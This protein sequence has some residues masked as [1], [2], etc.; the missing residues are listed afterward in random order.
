[1]TT[2][3]TQTILE[4][5]DN[6]TGSI[7]IIAHNRPD[8]DSIGSVLGLALALD[9]AGKKVAIRSEDPVPEKYRFLPCVDL[10]RELDA[11][12]NPPVEL[13]MILD[14][15]DFDRI[16]A[17]K[18]LIPPGV[19]VIN[20]DH[21]A[22]NA[23]FGDISWIDPNTAATGEMIVRLLNEGGIRIPQDCAAG[24]LTA[25][26]TDTGSFQYAQTTAETLRIAANLI[27]AGAPIS[28]L[29]EAL[30]MQFSRQR[31][32][33]LARLLDRLNFACGG[34][35]CYAWLD[36]EI[37]R[38]TGATREETE[39]LIDHIRAI[40]GVVVA[41]ILERLPDGQQIRMSLRSKNPDVNVGAIAAIYGGG[42]HIAAAGAHIAEPHAEFESELVEH[43][44]KTIDQAAIRPRA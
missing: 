38:K 15:A 16:G 42:G 12:I 3:P 4:A 9:A 20:I 27:E 33:L 24:L 36:S 7:L 19:T 1:M 28:D 37:F 34:H 5:I 43:V 40:E 23:G 35:F 14:C 22:T 31:V 41:A 13:V 21:H 26:I 32:R 11:E 6:C 30:Y 29:C 10:I 39:G 44:C 17:A 8:G 25:I 2:Q 18:A